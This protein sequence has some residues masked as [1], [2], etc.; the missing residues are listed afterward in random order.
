MRFSAK[1][2][3]TWNGVNSYVFGNQWV[4]N[5]G[6]PLTLYFQVF[7]ADQATQ[8][9]SQGSAVF[10]GITPLGSTAGLRYLVGVGSSNQPYQ[11]SVT[12]PSIDDSKVLT[13]IATQ[14]DLNDSSIWQVTLTPSMV[15]SGG[16]VQF[17][18]QEGN[19]T[20]RFNVINMINVEYPTSNGM[21]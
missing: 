4:V 19:K 9:S 12:F 21:C 2:I 16:N 8:G 7:D 11:V 10:T 17:S 20:R 5:Q 1:P 13:L 3:I 14:A 15:I 6:D 18:I